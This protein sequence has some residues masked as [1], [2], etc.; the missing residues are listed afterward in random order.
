MCIVLCSNLRYERE[1]DVRSERGFLPP[2]MRGWFGARKR[3]LPRQFVRL[4][5]CCARRENH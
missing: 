3:P 2:E 4:Q 5:R 1:C